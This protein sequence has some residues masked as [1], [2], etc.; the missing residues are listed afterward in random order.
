MRQ[1]LWC[2]QNTKDGPIKVTYTC[3]WLEQPTYKKTDVIG[4]TLK[5]ATPIPVTWF[6]KLN[7]RLKSESFVRCDTFDATKRNTSGI[8]A[9]FPLKNDRDAVDQTI[10][11]SFD[12]KKDDDGKKNIVATGHYFHCQQNTVYSPSISIGSEI[13]VSVS[14]STTNVYHRIGN[15]P[16]VDFATK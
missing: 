2:T 7:Y 10:I 16:F 12:C 4:V 13:S 3:M 11:I 1:I 9:K 14:S 8:A 6:G 15:N 5:N